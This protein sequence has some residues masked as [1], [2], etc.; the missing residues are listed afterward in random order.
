MVAGRRGGGGVFTGSGGG[1]GSEEEVVFS[2]V[3]EA[4]AVCW[5]LAASTAGISGFRGIWREARDIGEGRGWNS[6][7]SRGFGV[8]IMGPWSRDAVSAVSPVP[9]C[10]GGWSSR[11][12]GEF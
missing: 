4:S 7:R 12:A 2:R 6:R 11:K 9:D 1:G 5:G 3:S 10:R 8:G